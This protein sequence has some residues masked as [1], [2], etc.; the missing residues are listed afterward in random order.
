MIKISGLVHI[1][2]DDANIHVVADD[3]GLQTV[4]RSNPIAGEAAEGRDMRGL[5]SVTVK[6]AGRSR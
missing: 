3:L 2:V 6:L 1:I 4:E 5:A